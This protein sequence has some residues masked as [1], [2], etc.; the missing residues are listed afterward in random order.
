[1]SAKEKEGCLEAG[2]AF[3]VGM[4]FLPITYALWGF[5]TSRLWLWFVVP[6]FDLAPLSIPVAI[7]LS[8]VLSQFKRSPKTDKDKTTAQV[9]AESIGI[10]IGNPLFTLAVG[11]ALHHWFM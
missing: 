7:G 9:V 4:A 1:M 2:I 11:A 3:A 6:Q 10:G 8:L 5:T